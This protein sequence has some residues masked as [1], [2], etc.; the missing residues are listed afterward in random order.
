MIPDISN[1]VLRAHADDL[2]SLACMHPS[3]PPLHLLLR[4]R[5]QARR[6][7]LA[8]G[9]GIS[10]HSHLLYWLLICRVERNL[11]AIRTMKYSSVLVTWRLLPLIC[12]ELFLLPACPEHLIMYLSTPFTAKDISSNQPPKL[13]HDGQDSNACFAYGL[14]SPQVMS[15]CATPYT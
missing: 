10:S 14:Q 3:K 13:T 7:S 11:I 15:V 2:T 12:W 1:I 6:P 5:V 8:R 9:S 4:A